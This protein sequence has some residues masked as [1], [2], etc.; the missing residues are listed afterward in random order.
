MITIMRLW[1][2]AGLILA[3]LPWID[4]HLRRH[5]RLP[6]MSE[7][8]LKTLILWILVAILFAPFGV[9]EYAKHLLGFRRPT[10]SK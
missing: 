8:P 3:A 2:E 9:F 7:S 1:L 5:F 4:P 6:V 10:I